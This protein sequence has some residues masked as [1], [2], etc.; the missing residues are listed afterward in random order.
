[1]LKEGPAPVTAYAIGVQNIPLGIEM[2]GDE[3]KDVQRNT[4]DVNEG[5]PPLA[6]V[7]QRCRN[8]LIELRDVVE[9]KTA[10]EVSLRPRE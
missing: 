1:M 4:V 10:E 3:R 2:G 5:V 7:C 9:G 8:V 6:N